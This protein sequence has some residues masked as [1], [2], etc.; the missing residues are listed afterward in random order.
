MRKAK[1]KYEKEIK[2]WRKRSFNQ[3]MFYFETLDAVLTIDEDSTIKVR[4][5]ESSFRSLD[6]WEE[7]GDRLCL[8]LNQKWY[9]NNVHS[10]LTKVKKELSEWTI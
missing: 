10:K 7:V 8:D 9:L 2:E 4:I 1:T 6:S 5:G 3:E